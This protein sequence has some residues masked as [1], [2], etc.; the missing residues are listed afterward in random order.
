[1]TAREERI[2][3]ALRPFVREGA[4]FEAVE[5]VLHDWEVEWSCAGKILTA[6]FPR[7]PQ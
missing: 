5:E 7:S 4:T 2:I 1:M 6:L 3:K